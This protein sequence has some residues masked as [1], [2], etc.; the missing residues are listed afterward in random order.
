MSHIPDTLVWETAIIR[1]VPL[2]AQIAWLSNNNTGIPFENTRV[3]PVIQ[4]AVTHG[5]GEPET[6]NGHPAI[7]YG[8][9]WVTTGC[10]LT[11][12]LGFGVTGCA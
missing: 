9:D 4:V 6:L 11:S 8:T 2:G 12:T 5:T 7:M 3:A 10:P 1:G